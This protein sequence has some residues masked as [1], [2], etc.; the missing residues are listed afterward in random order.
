[1]YATLGYQGTLTVTRKRVVEVWFKGAF[2][3]RVPYVVIQGNT[4]F[5]RDVTRARKLL[6]LRLD[7]EV[8]W[9]LTPWSWF[10]DWF[11]NISDVIHN[12]NAFSVN[13]LVMKYGY[14][15][16]KET[17]EDTYTHS[18]VTWK[19]GAS[20]GEIS[21]TFRTV[22]KRRVKAHPMGFGLTDE[23][24]DARRLAILAALGLSF[25]RV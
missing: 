24:L 6:G 19:D 7:S 1:M 15:M 17:I 20:S 13:D 3:Y 5:E 16:Y 12:A 21:E 2:M 9:N 8:L 18:G 11:V 25:G 22:L 4:V 14:L 10:A 23:G